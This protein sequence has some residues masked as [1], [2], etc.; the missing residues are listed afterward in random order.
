MRYHLRTLLIVLAVGP[1]IVLLLAAFSPFKNRTIWE[2]SGAM[3]AATVIAW[4]VFMAIGPIRA[5]W[6]ALNRRM[7]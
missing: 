7:H 1:V 2:L 4:T 5:G 3:F 6:H